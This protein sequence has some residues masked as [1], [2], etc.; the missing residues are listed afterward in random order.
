MLGMDG[1]L[2]R[3]L[4]DRA[5]LLGGDL[6]NLRGARRSLGCLAL[7]L[8]G[9]A[10]LLCFRAL[11]RG[12]LRRGLCLG[13]L[14]CG[15]RSRGLGLTPAARRIGRGSLG[16][17]TLARRFARCA[18]GRR[19]L[20]LDGGERDARLVEILH[21]AGCGGLGGDLAC[22]GLLGRAL[23]P[24]EP[25]FRRLRLCD[26]LLAIRGNLGRRAIAGQ[27]GL[28]CCGLC[29]LALARCPGNRLLRGFFADLGRGDGRAC[30]V[31]ERLDLLRLLVERGQLRLR[32]LLHLRG[33][34]PRCF[35]ALPIALCFA[36]VDRGG[37]LRR[38]GLGTRGLRLDARADGIRLGRICLA[39]RTQ[40]DGI[41]LRHIVL[42][43]LG[44]HA[45]LRSVAPRLL[46]FDPGSLRLGLGPRR[47]GTCNL[48][49]GLDAR[50][51][52]LGLRRITTRDLGFLAGKL[53]LGTRAV[54][55]SELRGGIALHDLGIR[56]RASR[57]VEA[58]RRVTLRCVGFCTAPRDVRLGESRFLA[59]TLC[60]D[61][62]LA[63]RG[64]GEVAHANGLVDSDRDLL[65]RLRRLVLCVR[66]LGLCLGRLGVRCHGSRLGLL[67]IFA[68]RL[69]T[70][71]LCL[72][73]RA[74]RHLGARH[75]LRGRLAQALRFG[76]G[77]GTRLLCLGSRLLRN[78]GSALRLLAL[79]LRP[80]ERLG[81][82]CFRC[83]VTRGHHDDDLVAVGLDVIASG[84]RERHDDA[85]HLATVVDLLCCDRA[86][87]P[88]ARREDRCTFV[89]A[90][91]LGE[92]RLRHVDDHATGSLELVDREG[93][94]LRSVDVHTCRAP[95]L[96]EGDGTDLV[97]AI[98]LRR[99]GR[100]CDDGHDERGEH[101]S[102]MGH[103]HD[104]SS[105]ASGQT[106]S[107][108]SQRRRTL[109]QPPSEKIFA[110]LGCGSK[111]SNE[112][113]KES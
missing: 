51:I 97:L 71:A 35:R 30:L 66:R 86:D 32:V 34:E 94:R 61:Q 98:G 108:A 101:E 65:L 95:V 110:R 80:G 48:C 37:S 21:R 79:G 22:L 96:V 40:C 107:F 18:L 67:D 1:L 63:L 106:R 23:R 26:Q 15:E 62:R 3:G 57:L 60:V 9:G 28:L 19:A 17:T 38:L 53:G 31:L 72:V 12:D 75:L 47:V 16:L 13:A 20:L 92:P 46:D 73:C 45:L 70:G 10:L 89:T 41:G 27:R 50:C 87:R 74:L 59:R 5:L 84:A 93:R 111:F 43:G 36:P 76:L 82:R 91:R 33:L 14:A 58:H 2:S 68:A 113:P 104:W 44:F 105:S 6:R 24:C 29:H 54:R 64:L 83:R 42:R 99:L 81:V 88:R 100:E 25:L 55:R 52:I 39:L 56:L 4:G 102:G 85:H 8:C 112:M 7:R 11:L 90:K 103:V 109:D 77:C 78:G 49:L 69:L